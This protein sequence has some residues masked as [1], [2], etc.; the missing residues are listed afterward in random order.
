MFDRYNIIA[1]ADLARA[2]ARR[3]SPVERR[4]AKVRQRNRAV[5]PSLGS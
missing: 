4:N 1:Q 5:A 3:S 2:V